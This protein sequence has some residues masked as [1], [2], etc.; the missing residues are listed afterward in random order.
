MKVMAI[1]MMGVG[2][3][4]SILWGDDY[5]LNT[6]V[7]ADV[8]IAVECRYIVVCAVIVRRRTQTQTQTEVLAK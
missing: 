1:V 8:Y 4:E 3:T 5:T 7:V 2:K 6:D